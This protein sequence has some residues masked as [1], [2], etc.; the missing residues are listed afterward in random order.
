MS[1]RKSYVLGRHPE[2]RAVRVGGSWRISALGGWASGAAPSAAAAWRDASEGLGVRTEEVLA[3]PI[4]DAE[5]ASPALE[6][7][8]TLKG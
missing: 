8:A 5:D 1:T 6:F 3:G 4:D 2:A 7:L